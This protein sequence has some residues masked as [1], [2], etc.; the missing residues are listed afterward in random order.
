MGG[1]GDIKT[2]GQR[3]A[4]GESLTKGLYI[5]EMRERCVKVIPEFGCVIACATSKL[6]TPSQKC[7]AAYSLAK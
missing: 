6:G 2:E 7:P 1:K 3:A 4:G 5:D